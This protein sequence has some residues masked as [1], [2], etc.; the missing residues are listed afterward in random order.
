MSMLFKHKGEGENLAIIEAL[1]C[2]SR[3]LANLHHDES[4]IR[5]SLILANINTTIKETLSSTTIDEWLFGKNLSKNVKAAKLITT[6]FKDL[7]QPHKSQWT[8]PSKNAKIPPHQSRS[9]SQTTTKGGRRYPLSH[10]TS[11]PAYRHRRE[12]TR[13]RT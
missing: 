8:K 5:R 4:A 7:K 2:T 11:K 1:G 10:K 13:R 6:S 9:G 3:L 12:H